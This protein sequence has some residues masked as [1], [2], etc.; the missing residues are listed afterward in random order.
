MTSKKVCAFCPE[1]ANLTGE[2][3]FAAWIDRLLTETTTH[4]VFT[5]IDPRYGVK[6]RWTS[7]RLNRTFKVV[8]NRCNNGWMSEIDNAARDALKDVIQYKSPVCFLRRGI[9]SMA[10]FTLKNALVADYTH[11]KPF[12]GSY[13]RGQFKHGLQFPPG[14]YMWL[15]CVRTERHIRHGICATRYGKPDIQAVNGVETYMFTWS[16]ESLLLQLVATRWTNLSLAAHGRPELRQDAGLDDTFVPFWPVTGRRVVW[17][18]RNAISHNELDMVADRF[19][20][21]R[22]I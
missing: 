17:P 13:Y 21:I 1:T 7:R 2:H 14:I 19:R 20:S 6:R 8:C 12:F 4:Y 18:P 10:A 5:D 3:L 9:E 16:A 22:F 15:G 11:V